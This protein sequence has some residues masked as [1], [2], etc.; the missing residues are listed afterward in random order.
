MRPPDLT[1]TI[2]F[3]TRSKK[4]QK[5]MRKDGKGMV[6][7][8]ADDEQRKAIRSILV[9]R[10]HRLPGNPL[11]PAD[12][13]VVMEIVRLIGKTKA[14]DSLEVR[15]WDLGPRTDSRGWDRDTQNLHETVCDAMERLVF[16]KDRQV[17]HITQM[18]KKAF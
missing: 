8:K 10:L 17:C 18:R 12:H 4:N 9:E 2:P 5:V 3:S 7:R 15:V 1:F 11:I 13:E 16:H 14:E 6:Y